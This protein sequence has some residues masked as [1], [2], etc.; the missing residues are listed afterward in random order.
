MCVYKQ[1]YSWES[2]FGIKATWQIYSIKVIYR[3]HNIVPYYS[4]IN[5]CNY[6]KG[7]IDVWQLKGSQTKPCYSFVD[8]HSN[9]ISHLCLSNHLESVMTAAGPFLHVHHK[10]DGLFQTQQVD[11]QQWVRLVCILFLP[12]PRMKLTLLLLWSRLYKDE[13]DIPYSSNLFTHTTRI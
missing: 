7:N 10:K 12:L 1:I 13:L 5:R 11:A 2:Y 6:F 3:T 4:Q 8:A 9:K